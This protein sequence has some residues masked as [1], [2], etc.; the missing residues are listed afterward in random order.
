MKVGRIQKIVVHQS[1][2]AGKPG[3]LRLRL[4]AFGR[5]VGRFVVPHY[6]DE[7]GVDAVVNVWDR[8]LRLS[9]RARAN[10]RRVLGKI[11]T[12]RTTTLV[13]AA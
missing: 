9:V 8:Q 12:E 11:M 13:A 10:L 2:V 7:S 5:E 1:A 4:L 6:I 3:E